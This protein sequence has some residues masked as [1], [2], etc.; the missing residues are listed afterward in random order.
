MG[1]DLSAAMLGK[2]EEKD[3]DRPVR[4]VLGDATTLP[5]VEDAFGGAYCRWVLHLISD[6]AAAVRELCR[7][8]RPGGAIVVHPG[9]YSGE[10]RVVW[11]RMVDELGPDAEP[12]GLDINRGEQQLDDAFASAGATPLGTA[13]AAGAYESSLARFFDEA[14]QRVYSWTWRVSDDTLERAIATVRAW[15]EERYGDLEVA[16]LPIASH[17][18]RIYRI[19][20]PSGA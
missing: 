3:R 9:G 20:P 16:F 13:P 17:D 11:R 10:W 7:A 18:W 5:F 2:L 8:V 12:V 14:A 19:E 15:A 1:L 6:W 4:L